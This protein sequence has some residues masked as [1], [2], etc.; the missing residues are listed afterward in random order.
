MK[1]LLLSLAVLI[2]G[3]MLFAQN[4]CSKKHPVYSIDNSSAPK[5][6]NRLG[7]DPEFPFLEHLTT[8]R[9]VL[10][11][12]KSP[13]NRK[14]HPGKMKEMDNML[15]EIGFEHGANDVRLSC[16]TSVT[17]PS[18]TT[19]NMGNGKMNYSYVEMKG[20]SH[21]AWRISA[22]NGCYITFFSDCGNAFYAG[23]NFGAESKKS[24]TGCKEVPV[25]ISSDPK[26]ITI[27]ES[28]KRHIIKKTY[29]YYIKEGCG[30]S[31]CTDADKVY[32][33][34]KP[35]LVKKEDVT[36]QLPQTYKVSTSGTGTATIC[37]GKTTE[38][39]A[40]FTVEKESEYLGYSKPDVR[41]EFIQ[42]S[43]REYK[44]TMRM[45]EKSTF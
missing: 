21:K 33:R 15:M 45:K 13:S 40:D 1:R 42:V 11:V 32:D 35:L 22:E 8:P 17:I 41:K 16:I 14:K 20:K 43:K 38:V 31:D 10:A 36:E 4:D 44:R 39:H 23:D 5:T 37:K 18:G 6:I 30:C 27:T 12:L 29:I 24:Y 28:P 25:T 7:T 34:S 26:E 2:P 19:G 3:T 9:Q